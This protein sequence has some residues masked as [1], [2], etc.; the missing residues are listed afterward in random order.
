MVKPKGW[1]QKQVK[2][3]IKSAGGGVVIPIN[4]EIKARSKILNFWFVE[5]LLKKSKTIAVGECFCRKKVKRCGYTLAG[6]LYLNDWGESA[7]AEGYA[8]RSNQQAAIKILKKTYAE[9]LVLVSGGEEPPVK[10]C[11]CCPCCCFLF[12]GQFQFGLRD[13]LT[14]SSFVAQVNNDRCKSC[15]RCTKRC[16]FGALT[17]IDAKLVFNQDKCFGCGLCINTCKSLAIRLVEI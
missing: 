7:I 2:S 9:G 6:C 11:S 13:S 1:T 5:R 12:A 14:N 4:R 3:M 15:G 17:R 8:R 10:I 16:H